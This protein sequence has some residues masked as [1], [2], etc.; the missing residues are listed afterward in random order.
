MKHSFHILAEQVNIPV[1]FRLD[2]PTRTILLMALLAIVIIGM[3][4]VLFT[5][6]GARWVRRSAKDGVRKTNPM[7][8]EPRAKWITKLRNP[9]RGSSSETIASDETR[10]DTYVE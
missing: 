2:P 4:L 1:W 6:L 8:N 7:K 10:D 9:F 5:M 3:A